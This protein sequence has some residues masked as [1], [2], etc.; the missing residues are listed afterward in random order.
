MLSLSVKEGDVVQIGPFQLMIAR[1]EGSYMNVTLI[2]VEG[3]WDIGPDCM[4]HLAHGVK[5][6]VSLRNRLMID[7]PN[8]KVMRGPK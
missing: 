7:A 1:R 3:D 6:G 5:V 4:A 8:M 2:G